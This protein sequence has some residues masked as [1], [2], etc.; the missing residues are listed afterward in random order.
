M[1]AEEAWR[2]VQA[3]LIA[4]AEA[5]INGEWSDGEGDIEVEEVDGPTRPD[6]NAV[7][8][9]SPSSD[10]PTM[11]KRGRLMKAQSKAKAKPAAVAI[12]PLDM[13]SVGQP[14]VGPTAAP[15]AAQHNASRG[16]PVGV[17]DYHRMLQHGYNDVEKFRKDRKAGLIPRTRQPRVADSARVKQKAETSTGTATSRHDVSSSDIAQWRMDETTSL[18]KRKEY[19]FAMRDR[20]WSFAQIMEKG[21]FQCKWHILRDW[22]AK[23]RRDAANAQ[24]A[25]AVRAER[26]NN[27][28]GD[29]PDHAGPFHARHDSTSPISSLARL[30]ETGCEDVYHNQ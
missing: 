21:N 19:V 16:R 9:D 2:T 15:P 5:K 4:S 26:T 27:V 11:K 20:G 1:A 3:Q 28:K 12:T 14:R 24:R 22:T 7:L 23:A 29:C 17:T 10:P 25:V 18:A 30:E 6:L 13:Q 8:M